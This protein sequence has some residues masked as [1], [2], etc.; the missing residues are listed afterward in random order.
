MTTKRSSLISREDHRI[1]LLKL[2]EDR[3]SSLLGSRLDSAAKWLRTM[4]ETFGV[5]RGSVHVEWDLVAFIIKRRT[6]GKSPK[7][8]RHPEEEVT[9]RQMDTRTKSTSGSVAVMIP[10]LVIR[11]RGIRRRQQ[12]VVHVTFGYELLR[13]RKSAFV[14]VQTPYVQDD[15]T[16]FW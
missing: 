14:M 7:Q 16:A 1:H 2:L 6:E 12:W 11:R 8:F 10:T 4:Q 9:L 5:S 13:I 15:R 3:L